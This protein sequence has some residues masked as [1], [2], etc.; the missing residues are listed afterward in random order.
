MLTKEEIQALLEYGVFGDE[1][2]YGHAD[3]LARTVIA[4]HQQLA[5]AKAAQALVV[6]K[7]RQ[8]MAAYAAAVREAENAETD[9]LAA[10]IAASWFAH[11]I[12]LDHPRDDDPDPEIGPRARRMMADVDH[13]LKSVRALADVDG[14]ALLAELRA[15]RDVAIRQRDDLIE[16]DRQAHPTMCAMRMAQ[17]RAEADRDRLAA[18]NAALEDRV[19]VL[20]AAVK[21]A[22]TDLMICA[23]NVRYAAKTDPRW[24]GTAEVLM[25]R[26]RQIDA[27]LAA[28]GGDA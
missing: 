28:A 25:A 8:Y 4:L 1:N 10:D 17:A 11:W 19:R 13:A 3:G 20:V 14:M 23:D 12:K 6:G 26:C 22:R 18:A 16:A 9:D 27:A 21:D 24:E 2:I 5:D 7:V 15:E